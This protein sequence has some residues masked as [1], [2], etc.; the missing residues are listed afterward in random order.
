[1]LE[2]IRLIRDMEVGE[3]GDYIATLPSPESEWLLH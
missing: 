1:M 3:V 2:T